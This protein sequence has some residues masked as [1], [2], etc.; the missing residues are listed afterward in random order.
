MKLPKRDNK[1]MQV[2][3]KTV[4]PLSL[5]NDWTSPSWA[6]HQEADTRITWV[7][8]MPILRP[9]GGVV[10]DLPFK[11]HPRYAKAGRLL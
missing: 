9:T 10:Q 11:R 6:R 7:I 4:V 2:F 3:K 8:N 1:L 5:Q